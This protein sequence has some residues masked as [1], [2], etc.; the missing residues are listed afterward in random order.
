MA[1]CACPAQRRRTFRVLW[2]GS[3]EVPGT[4]DGTSARDL[5]EPPLCAAG[6]TEERR[7]GASVP[8][9]QSRP[10][11]SRHDSRLPCF[12]ATEAIGAL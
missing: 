2:T 5:P 4:E 11:T 7:G 10:S 6:S 1:Q 12:G 8:V 9:N 3:S